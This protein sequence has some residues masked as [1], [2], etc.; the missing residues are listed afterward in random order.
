M[1]FSPS[2][3]IYA[4]RIAGKGLGVFARRPIAAGM[5]IERAPVIVLP[6]SE[7]RQMPDGGIVGHYAFT[8][9][10]RSVAIALGFG[11]LY[12]HAVWPNAVCRDQAPRTKV[13]VARVAIEPDAEITINYH[14]EPGDDA[15]VDFPVRT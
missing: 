11:S 14:G 9:N 12:N 6:I 1:A 8:W 15:A 4:K 2:P 10:D 13:F 7:V 3:L 5:E